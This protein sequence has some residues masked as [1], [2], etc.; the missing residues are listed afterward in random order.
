M[1]LIRVLQQVF[2]GKKNWELALYGTAQKI[3]MN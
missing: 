1:I 3:H 2:I